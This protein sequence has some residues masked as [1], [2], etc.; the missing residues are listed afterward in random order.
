M[1]SACWVMSC[2]ARHLGLRSCLHTALFPS[3]VMLICLLAALGIQLVWAWGKPDHGLESSLCA[4][5][6]FDLCCPAPPKE[7]LTDTAETQ[8]ARR[9]DSCSASFE[10][11][12]SFTPQ[13]IMSL[14][15]SALT[16]PF[17]TLCANSSRGLYPGG[18]SSFHT[19]V[20]QIAEHEM[21]ASGLGFVFGAMKCTVAGVPAG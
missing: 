13:N 8:G 1:V 21:L 6:V 12:I 11:S 14:K 19:L 16:F 20:V 3:A 10:L 2:R 17:W 5:S 9:A 4:R 15:T 18:R 7:V